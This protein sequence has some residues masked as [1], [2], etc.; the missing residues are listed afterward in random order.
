MTM[1]PFFTSGFAADRDRSLEERLAAS[2]AQ[3]RSQPGS[4]AHRWSLFQLLCVSGQWE[5]AVQQLQVYAQLDPE[6]ARAAQAY[7]DLIR[8]ERWRAKVMAGRE[9]PG[10]V[11]EA[12]SW[13]EG[14]LEALRLTADGKTDE[15]DD[16]REAALDRAPMVAGHGINER[17]E[18]I[19]DSDS[20]FGPVCEIVAGGHYRW[21]P[22][23]NIAAWQV[24]RPSMPLDLVWAACTLTLVDGVAVR[25][26]MP[27]RYPDGQEAPGAFPASDD[28][29]LG[30]KTV[31]QQSGRTGVIA[32]GQKTWTTSAGDMSLFELA[33]C[34]FG[35]H[36]TKPGPAR[37]N[38]AR[39][40]NDDQA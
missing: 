1:E 17:F 36:A 27:A 37:A 9:L 5:R 15:A 25:G 14:L 13:I 7:R 11:F 4:P 22:L 26:F 3:V 2:E 19:S 31:W 23:S 6:Q 29:R 39:E 12:P 16:A 34:E 38:E 35:D 21:L 18:W 33:A 8:A 10:F 32:Q 20:R 40:Q 24:E 28:L 30:R